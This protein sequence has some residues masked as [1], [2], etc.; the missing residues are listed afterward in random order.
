MFTLARNT[1]IRE[2]Y[3]Q[4]FPVLLHLLENPIFQVDAQI[5]QELSTWRDGILLEE[6]FVYDSDLL[7]DF[8]KYF[9]LAGGL[10][11][12][13]STNKLHRTWTG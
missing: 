9:F 13:I 8:V 11:S 6:F 12:S 10:K 1:A 3:L 7:H 5:I 4:M 2:E